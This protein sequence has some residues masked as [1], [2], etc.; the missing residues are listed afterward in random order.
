MEK[1]YKVSTVGGFIEYELDNVIGEASTREEAEKIAREY[2]AKANHSR[3]TILEVVDGEAE[4]D[5]DLTYYWYAVQYPEYDDLD[6]GSWDYDTAVAMAK[7]A[8][9]EHGN[10]KIAYINVDTAFCEDVEEI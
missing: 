5:E 8:A 9:K 3:F 2:A 7:E 10:A 4:W 1:I 6:V